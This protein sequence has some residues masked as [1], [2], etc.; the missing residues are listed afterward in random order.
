MGL[1]LYFTQTEH[2][3]QVWGSLDSDWA[4]QMREAYARMAGAE[5]RVVDRAEA[6]DLIVFWEPHQDRQAVWAPNL[7]AH[8]LVRKHPDRVFVVSVEDHPLGFLPG[9]Y[10][11]L[12]RHR[13]D[14]RR[15]RTC[16]YH[17]TPNP[18]VET[19]PRDREPALLA[20]FVGAPSHPLRE[21]FFARAAE[22]RRD[23]IAVRRSQRGR[24]NSDPGDP[25]LEQERRA[26][27][28]SILDAKFSLCLRGNGVGTFRVQESLAL[29]RAPVIVS[30]EWVPVSGPEWERFAVFVA[31]RDVSSLPRILREHEPR[32]REMGELAR[33]AYLRFFAGQG[34]LRHA[35]EQIALLYRRRDHDERR[36]VAQWDEW[37]AAERHRRGGLEV[38]RAF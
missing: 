24:F 17:R 16:F 11:S 19:A 29:A 37:I 36:I 13:F 34:Y 5:H 7:R 18:G 21:W 20:S 12:P 6:A 4:E 2:E 8:P 31:E 1:A 10:T 22:L 25:A 15:H 35:V 26:Y 3:P 38:A 27:V 9:L 33:D 23:G 32:W 30:D 28:D 14:P